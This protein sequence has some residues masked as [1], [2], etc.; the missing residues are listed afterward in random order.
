MV[1]MMRLPI[2]ED[3]KPGKVHHLPED[4][5]LKIRQPCREMRSAPVNAGK[6]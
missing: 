3:S 6:Q 4:Q 1:V 2:C 5:Y